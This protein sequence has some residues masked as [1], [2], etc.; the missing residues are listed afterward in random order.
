MFVKRIRSVHNTRDYIAV[1]IISIVNPWTFHPF[2]DVKIRVSSLEWILRENKIR[3]FFF[4]F[5]DLYWTG[6]RYQPR[7]IGQ[8]RVRRSNSLDKKPGCFRC[9][10]CNKGY[11]WLRNMKNHL[12]NECGKDPTEFCPYCPHRTKYKSSLQK[13]ILRIHLAHNVWHVEHFRISLFTL[14]G[15]QYQSRLFARNLSNVISKKN[16]FF[17]ITNKFLPDS[18]KYY[19][20]FTRVFYSDDIEKSLI[21]VTAVQLLRLFTYRIHRIPAIWI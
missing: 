5:P 10:S 15:W 1:H 6:Y 13:H 17:C 3:F 8:R 9:P 18:R 2:D 11:R 12:R 21:M 7:I 20:R 19:I 14:H 16:F 4:F